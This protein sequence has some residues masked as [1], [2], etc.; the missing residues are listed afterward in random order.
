MRDVQRYQNNWNE[1]DERD[2]KQTL[3]EVIF[4]KAYWH[5]IKCLKVNN[6][7]SNGDTNTHTHTFLGTEKKHTEMTNIRMLYSTH[8]HNRFYMVG[9]ELQLKYRQNMLVIDTIS[10]LRLYMLYVS[11]HIS[12]S[13]L[14]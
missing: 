10:Q 5:K 12:V 11:I 2:W 9:D 14:P 6:G 8:T 7:V 1:R 4:C 3:A 13:N